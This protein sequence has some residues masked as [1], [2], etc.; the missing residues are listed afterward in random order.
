MVNFSILR[1]LKSVILILVLAAV[2]QVSSAQECNIIYVTPN[3][4][5][6]SGAGTKA[7]PASF[8]HALSI[9]NS[10]NDKIYMSGG[11]YVVSGEVN[12]P[13]N[14]T[15]EGGF[16]ANWHKSNG[17][18]TT[19]FR[20]N[21][22]PIPGVGA[23]IG[24]NCVN[25][26]NFRLQ[27]LTIRVANAVGEGT[28]TYGVYL[29]GSS[30]YEMVRC[31]VI[32]GNGG[33]GNNGDPGT[34]GMNGA[35]GTDGEEGDEDGPCCRL[36]GTGAS[37]SFP[38]SN[39]GGDGGDGGERG[40]YEEWS[41][42]GETFP[43]YIGQDGAGVGAG[44]GGAGGLGIFTTIISIQC[45]RTPV[46]DG[47]P[48]GD[49]ADG[50]MGAPGTPGN[51]NF[52]G[53]WFVPGSGTPG[54]PG[55]HGAGGGGGGGGGSQ[56]G[57][58]YETI[59]NLIENSNGSGPGG[60][61]GGEGGQSGTGGFG[62]NGG[63]ASFGVFIYN[64]GPGALIR[65]CEF[66]SGLP[67]L[68]GV[69]GSGG[70]G[71]VGGDGGLGGGPF[72]CDV[73]AGGDGGEG[74]RGGNG[75]QGGKGSNGVTYPYYEW[76]GGTAVTQMNVNSL[77]QPIVKVNYSGCTNSP[78]YFSTDA[79]GTV[80]WYFGAGSNPTTSSGTNSVCTYTTQGRKTFTMVLNGIAYTFSDFIDIDRAGVNADPEIISSSDSVC[81][82]DLGSFASSVSADDYFWTLIVG[83]DTLAMNGPTLQTLANVPFDTAGNFTLTLNTYTNCCGMSFP[84][85][86]DVFVD[87]LILPKV[88]IQAS[89]EDSTN[90]LCDGETVTF[91]ASAEDVGMFPSYDWLVNGSSQGSGSTFSSSTLADG[92]Q[93]SCVVTSSLLCATGM[94]DTSNVI[95]VNVIDI[96]QITCDADSFVT[97]DPTFFSAEVTTGGLP[98]YSFYWDF[99]DF[100][101]GFGD[102]VAHIYTVDGTYEVNVEVVDSNGCASNCSTVVI[103]G[104]ALSAGFEASA[105]Q[106]CAPL[107]VDFTNTSSNAITYFWDFGNGHYSASQDPSETYIFPGLYDV[108]MWA[109]NGE[110][111]DSVYVANQ[112]L[113]LES[114]VANFQ[115]FPEHVPQQGDTVY[116]FDNSVGAVT[117]EWNFG[118]PASGQDPNVS[119]EQ[120]PYHIFSGNGSYDVTLIVTNDK[121]CADTLVIPSIILQNVGIDEGGGAAQYFGVRN[122]Y[123]VPF[124][125]ELNLDVFIPEADQLAIDITDI[126]GRSL[127]MLYNGDA[128]AGLQTIQLNTQALNLSEGIY[129]LNL[130]YK[131][132]RI[133]Q[134]LIL[135]RN[136]Q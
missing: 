18:T 26:S 72:N 124:D 5:N 74:G 13:S 63:G 99:G 33:N 87:S 15:I 31:R 43:G 55:T 77:S 94:K 9:A 2:W 125:S 123:P 105:Y 65:D 136:S 104:S 37:G 127:G 12:V 48:G 64:N 47:E 40:T 62:G 76:T 41:T 88:Q 118:D 132:R 75:G 135:Q 20:D 28:S 60:G 98:P 117:W 120:N 61:G 25:K 3:G 49:G 93:I 57:L 51:Y 134:K 23:L 83:E 53:G 27:D 112:V 7:T 17:N 126:T 115:A 109:F 91:S 130:E 92:D 131:G 95:T 84:A 82:G 30:N 24:V 68:G 111:N 59:F 14:I 38:G 54:Q 81:I 108:G 10:S 11:T 113:V 32:A 102:S 29:S 114:P 8:S 133:T 35:A 22:N 16:D 4:T 71:G 6:G 42:D 116:F 96:P 36:G 85:S 69:G 1:G 45:D 70:A 73:G 52:T 21:T 86:F 106:G 44:V 90:T 58:F 19:I 100:T 78:V 80:N 56:G 67:G 101:Q 110:G 97:H 79:T 107:T 128:P 121:G 103:L 34:N 129:L 46:N 50:V 119:Y 89:F 39:A 122:V 66:Q